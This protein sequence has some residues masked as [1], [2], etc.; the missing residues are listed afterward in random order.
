MKHR[1]VLTECKLLDSTSFPGWVSPSV[2]P[3]EVICSLRCVVMSAYLFCIVL[4]P[5]CL[6]LSLHLSFIK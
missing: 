1:S 5:I 4:Q 6:C 2:H 3:Q